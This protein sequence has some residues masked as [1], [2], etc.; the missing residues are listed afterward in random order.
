MV[1]QAG[2]DGGKAARTR[3]LVAL[4]WKIYRHAL[5]S[6]KTSLNGPSLLFN[7]IPDFKC[8]PFGAIKKRATTAAIRE[9]N[10]RSGQRSRGAWFS[11][12]DKL[13][14]SS[15]GLSRRGN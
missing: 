4:Y 15:Q 11:F 3:A 2:A 7:H 12:S 14:L 5:L 13:G 10:G 6:L 8:L 9:F 1:Y